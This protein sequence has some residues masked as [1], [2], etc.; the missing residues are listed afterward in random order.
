MHTWL[1]VPRLL[2]YRSDYSAPYRVHNGTT[3]HHAHCDRH[4][5]RARATVQQLYGS[6][7]PPVLYG[8]AVSIVTSLRIAHFP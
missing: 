5:G 4:L 7:M 8:G 1:R 3:G 6:H 2:H